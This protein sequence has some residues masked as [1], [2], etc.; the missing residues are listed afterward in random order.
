M[1]KLDKFL[2]HRVNRDFFEKPTLEVAHNLIGTYLVSTKNNHLQIGQIVETEAYIGT[3]DKACHASHGMTPRNK[4]MWD[5]A[6]HIYVYLI[7][8]MY[9]LVNIITESKGF[10]AAVLLRSLKPIEG[11][12]IPTNGPGKICKALN[13]TRTDTGLDIVKS[14]EL[15]IANFKEKLQIIKKPRIGIN[16]AGE[17]WVSK[18]WRFIK[19]E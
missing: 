16:Y 1:I 10:P 7:Y 19:A 3:D 12:D 5:E 8:G 2:K 13:L 9:H 14:N 11:I 18:D 4:I 6:G 15:F 17:P